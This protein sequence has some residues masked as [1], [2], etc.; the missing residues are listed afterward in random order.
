MQVVVEL[1]ATLADRTSGGLLCEEDHNSAVAA[2]AAEHES[3][4]IALGQSLEDERDADTVLVAEVTRLEE[5]LADEEASVLRLEGAL[6]ETTQR[7]RE[8][9]VTMTALVEE[10]T[11]Q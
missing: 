4:V 7:H 2:M 8:E 11:A 5:H 9:V 6:E 10:H 1:R 3:T